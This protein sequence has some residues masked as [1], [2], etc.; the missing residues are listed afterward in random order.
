MFEK[1]KMTV[2]NTFGGG[3]GS[4]VIEASFDDAFSKCTATVVV[5]TQGEYVRRR[6]M[7]GG[8]E[9]LYSAST[10]DVACAVADGNQLV[11]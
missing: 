4:R 5:T 10:S 1:Q 8:F 9:L 7:K 11:N 2:S 3:K 6:L